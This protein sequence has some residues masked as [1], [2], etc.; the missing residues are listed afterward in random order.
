[1]LIFDSVKARPVTQIHHPAWTSTPYKQGEAR[2]SILKLTHL[3]TFPARLSI[4]SAR[5]G[6]HQFHSPTPKHEPN[7]DIIRPRG[8]PDPPA[9]GQDGLGQ[10]LHGRA[11]L[12][13]GRLGGADGRGSVAPPQVHP[14]FVPVRACV[15]SACGFKKENEGRRS[16]P[17]QFQYFLIY[18]H[19]PAKHTITITQP[20]KTG[21]SKKGILTW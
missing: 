14:S 15:I 8:H 9:A 20:Q 10:R 18:S 16:D 3:K 7:A 21:S 6:L 12:G 4:H 19:P 11:G 13:A 2:H 1:M 5:T 17:S